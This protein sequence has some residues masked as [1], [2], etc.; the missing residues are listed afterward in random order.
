VQFSGTPEAGWRAVSVCLGY[1]LPIRSL[2][3]VW[4]I[5][6][7]NEPSGPYWEIVFSKRMF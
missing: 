2:R 4:D 6:D 5:L 3:R 1:G 7:V